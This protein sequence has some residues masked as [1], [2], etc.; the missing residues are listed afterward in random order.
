MSKMLEH[1]DDE[2]SWQSIIRNHLVTQRYEPL[3]NQ[4][5]CNTCSVE[6][7]PREEDI[8]SYDGIVETYTDRVVS[9]LLEG[10]ESHSSC[11]CKCG[12]AKGKCKLMTMNY[13]EEIVSFFLGGPSNLCDFFSTCVLA[14]STNNDRMEL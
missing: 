2:K 13:L 7:C 4:L 11:G 8:R 10:T 6:F 12:H 5:N 3:R 14:F 1:Y 9:V